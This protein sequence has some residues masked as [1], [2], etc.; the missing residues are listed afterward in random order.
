MID[1]VSLL[2][3]VDLQRASGASLATAHHFHDDVRDQQQHER[4]RTRVRS[5]MDRPKVVGM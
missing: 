1:D 5:E 2:R 4:I 3:K